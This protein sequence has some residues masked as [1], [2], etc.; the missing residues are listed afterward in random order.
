MHIA[1]SLRAVI[2]ERHM[3]QH[4]FYRAW[5]GGQLTLDILRRY[6]GQYFAQ[7]DAFPRFVSSVHSRC[8]HIEAR[9]VLLEN[10]VDE[11]IKGTDHPELWMR[12]AEGLGAKREDVAREVPLPETS[13]LLSEFFDLTQSDWTDG[14]CALYAYES[15]VPEVAAS[16]VSGLKSFYGIRDPRTLEFFTTHMK[17]DVVH[18]KAVEGLIEAHASPEPARRATR[19]A[20]DAL[21]GFLDGMARESGVS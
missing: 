6:A 5:T 14:L 21:W 17:Y 4:P 13:R 10:L 18:S 7:V 12:F 11:E 1:E 16:K 3:L 20:V 9:K 8:P 2:S 15:Q 19:R